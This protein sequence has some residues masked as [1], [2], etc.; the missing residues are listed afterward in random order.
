[1]LCFSQSAVLFPKPI[2][3]IFQLEVLADEGREVYQQLMIT[4][5]IVAYQ[6]D[7][8]PDDQC[9]DGRN[10]DCDNDCNVHHCCFRF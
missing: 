5:M 2:D 8:H 7:Q 4:P 1:M 9:H 6:D 3:F 10:N